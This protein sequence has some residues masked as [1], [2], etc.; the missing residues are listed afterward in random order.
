M[1][2]FMAEIEGNRGMCS[3][4]GNKAS[5]IWG[6]IRGWNVGIRV[7]GK[8]EDDEDKFY[9]YATSG[10]SNSRSS[11]L[12]CILTERDITLMSQKEIREGIGHAG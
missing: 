9:V 4:L 11:T 7:I 10:S 2:Q 6:H 5:G 1:A 8:Y 3:R 12:I